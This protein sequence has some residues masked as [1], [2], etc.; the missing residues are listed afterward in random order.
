LLLH[1]CYYKPYGIPFEFG[2]V[3]AE[4]KGG[5]C[6]SCIFDVVAQAAADLMIF[7]IVPWTLSKKVFEDPNIKL[8]KFNTAS[9]SFM[10]A[11]DVPPGSCTGFRPGC[12]RL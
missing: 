5:G 12:L 10:N 1:K 2:F 4:S 8:H 3:Q 11:D 6:I 9:A 7:N